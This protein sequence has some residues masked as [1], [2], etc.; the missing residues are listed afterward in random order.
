[1]GLIEEINEALMDIEWTVTPDVTVGKYAEEVAEKIGA[2]KHEV[3]REILKRD[4][5]ANEN[6]KMADVIARASAVPSKPA[7]P[8]KYKKVDDDSLPF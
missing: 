8:V 7:K 3:L 6:E 4:P 2:T 1:L 5:K